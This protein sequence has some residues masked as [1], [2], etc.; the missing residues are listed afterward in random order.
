MLL[1]D[2]MLFMLIFATSLIA[3]LAVHS[4]FR[5]TALRQLAPGWKSWQA[6]R[7]FPKGLPLGMALVFYLVLAVV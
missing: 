5:F 6:G 4:L 2:I 7:Y 3:A 1:A